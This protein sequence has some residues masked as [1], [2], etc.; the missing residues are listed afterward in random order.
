VAWV[1]D[2]LRELD[3][4]QLDDRFN[5]SSAT[6][7]LPSEYWFT[8]CYLS[9]SFLAPFEVA[10]RE[11]IGIRN[12]MWGS[13]YPHPEG[14]WPRTTVALRNTFEGVS[15]DE[16]RMILGDNA[17]GIY[18]L[19]RKALRPVVERIGPKP[20]EIAQPLLPEEFPEFRSLAFRLIGS[21]S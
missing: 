21:Y 6:T 16:T 13:D 4:I 8:N 20:P 10:M 3:S 17:V 19:D 11:Q 1:P 7:K 9:G 14:T 5:R 2:L 15:E 12:L 18:N